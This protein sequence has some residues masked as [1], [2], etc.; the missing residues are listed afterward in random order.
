[1][2]RYLD[3]R[4]EKILELGT[5]RRIYDVV[6]AHA[7]CHFREVGRRS[8][9]AEGS[10][11]YHLAFLL[12]HGLIREER[13][14]NTLRYFPCSI[15]SDQKKLLGFLR[16]ESVRRILL[17]ILNHENCNHEHIVAFTGLSPSTVSWHL[18]KLEEGGLVGSQRSG[19]KTFHRLLG[20]KDDLMKLLITYKASFFDALVDRA[21]EMWTE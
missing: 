4:E 2:P 16:Q 19:R 11:R 15:A 17:F 6:Q 7:G 5:R 21:V 9:L 8:G 20:N 13:E 12:K 18:R 14:G 10:A 1:M 3:E